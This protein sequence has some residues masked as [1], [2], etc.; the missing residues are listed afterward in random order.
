MYGPNEN[1]LVNYYKRRK[2]DNNGI[3]EKKKKVVLSP[4]NS[5]TE[6]GGYDTRAALPRPQARKSPI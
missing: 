5:E 2:L 4:A 1:R 3:T 6:D